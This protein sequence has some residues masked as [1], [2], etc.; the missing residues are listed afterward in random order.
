M[1]TKPRRV[2]ACTGCIKDMMIMKEFAN[3]ALGLSLSRTLPRSMQTL[4]SICQA[5]RCVDTFLSF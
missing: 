3:L 2:M 1:R 4:S 5:T